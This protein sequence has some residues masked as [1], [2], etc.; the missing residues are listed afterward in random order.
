MLAA[1]PSGYNKKRP[2]HAKKME[3]RVQPLDLKDV[4]MEKAVSSASMQQSVTTEAQTP[5]CDH[6]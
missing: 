1:K 3:A 4:G 2:K 6:T 5:H